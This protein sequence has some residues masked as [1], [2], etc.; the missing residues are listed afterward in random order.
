MKPRRDVAPYM[1]SADMSVNASISLRKIY[2]RIRLIDPT[3]KPSSLY[4]ARLKNRLATRRMR[5][6]VVR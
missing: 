2:K 4:Q 6:G 3:Y 1:A 5:P